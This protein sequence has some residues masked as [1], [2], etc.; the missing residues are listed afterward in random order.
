MK[1]LLS[2]VV[3]LGV[4]LF[5]S[6]NASAQQEQQKSGFNNNTPQQT[7][8]GNNQYTDDQKTLFAI[9][10]LKELFDEITKLNARMN[11]SSGDALDRVKTEH[12]KYVAEYIKQL[13][14]QEPLYAKDAKMHSA[15][16]AELTRL[17]G[18]SK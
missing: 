3:F 9:P 7:Q 4:T 13:E 14:R 2:I 1:T 6:S 5:Y 18:S 11:G 17:K 12:D 8:S 16:L 15:I 10:Y